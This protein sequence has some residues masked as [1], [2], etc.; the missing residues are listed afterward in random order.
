MKSEPEMEISMIVES[1]EEGEQ[2]NLVFVDIQ[3]FRD[4][5][6][7]FICKEFCLVSVDDKYHAFVKSP[8]RFEKL[9]A[10]YQRQA[11]YNTRSIHGLKYER[12]DVHLI[13][14][15]QTAYM[16]IVGKKVI[17]KGD[18]KVGW[19]KYL[20]RNC[21]EIECVNI[22]DLGYCKTLHDSLTEH[23]KCDYHYQN[24]WRKWRCA[25]ENALKLQEIV[26]NNKLDI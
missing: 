2:N 19:L 18:Q 3:G 5:G 11:N 9:S 21:G 25:S 8:F 6:N 20:F 26:M 7:R 12:G 16:K 22:E 14:F 10:E 13:D 24:F 4:V 23:E 1:D 15:L 17:V